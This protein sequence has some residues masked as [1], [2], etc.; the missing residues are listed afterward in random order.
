V[1][2]TAL[3]RYLPVTVCWLA[4]IVVALQLPVVLRALLVLG[5]AA[6]AVGASI[7][8][9][10]ESHDRLERAVLTVVL[11]LG[12]STLVAVLLSIIHS[13]TGLRELALLAMLSSIATTVR[14][15]RS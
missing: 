2:A 10:L 9:L 8:W 13:M 1:S 5:T 4:V 15:L 12:I 14:V 7:S 3:R 6:W 11:S